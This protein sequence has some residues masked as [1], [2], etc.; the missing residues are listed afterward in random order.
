MIQQP[1]S[2]SAAPP[3]PFQQGR[4]APPNQPLINTL[5]SLSITEKRTR[6]SSSSS[7]GQDQ[8][9]S[10]MDKQ[11]KGNQGKDKGKGKQQEKKRPTSWIGEPTGYSAGFGDD[12][13]VSRASIRSLMFGWSSQLSSPFPFSYIGCWVGG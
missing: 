9:H 3:N 12:F 2:Q 1:A 13:R 5:S 6:E 11:G 10:L 8:S 4:L 7:S